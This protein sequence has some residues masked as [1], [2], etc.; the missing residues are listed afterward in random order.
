MN[1]V[2]L[3]P[4]DRVLTRHRQPRT[5]ARP[6]IT[7]TEIVVEKVYPRDRL[8]AG[9]V[10]RR[11]CYVEGDPDKGRGLGRNHPESAAVSFDEV[12]SMLG[13]Q[14]ADLDAAGGFARMRLVLEVEYELGSN[15][16]RHARQTL[17]RL[18]QMATN[19]GLLTEGMED[20]TVESYR[21]AVDEIACEARQ[22]P[23]V[24]DRPRA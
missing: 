21:F 4:G 24:V 23:R 16:P 8:V 20:A 11:F 22:Q 14:A 13:P 18:A 7:D 6:V 9:Q 3:Q 15:T 17:Q 1:P 12:V 19:R 2:D 5:N 10:V